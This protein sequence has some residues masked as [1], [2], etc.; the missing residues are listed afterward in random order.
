M[1][2]D[3]DVAF[4]RIIQKRSHFMSRPQHLKI[5]I[6][7]HFF[8]NIVLQCD[9]QELAD[10]VKGDAFETPTTL[11]ASFLS[12]AQFPSAEHTTP[13]VHGGTSPQCCPERRWPHHRAFRNRFI[14]YTGNKFTITMGC[15]VYGSVGQRERQR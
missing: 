2:R 3:H 8:F 15:K 13:P 7:L 5:N 14:E 10:S 12:D 4:S 1:H 6:C 11:K 9:T